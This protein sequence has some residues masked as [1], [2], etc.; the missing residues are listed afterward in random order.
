MIVATAGAPAGFTVG[1]QGS[2]MRVSI[3]PPPN[4][5]LATGANE[6]P[7]LTFREVSKS[8]CLGRG[9]GIPEAAD[10]DIWKNDTELGSGPEARAIK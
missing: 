6:F 8:I 3:A 9:F 5:S 7:A 4:R 1:N 2:D 10:V